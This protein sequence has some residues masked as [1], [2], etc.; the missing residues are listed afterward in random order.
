MQRFKIRQAGI[1]FTLILTVLSIAG[2]NDHEATGDTT[3]PTVSSVAPLNNSGN[4][5]INTSTIATFS[6]AMDP[7]SIDNATFRVRRPDNTA[8]AG[9]V[10]PSGVNAVFTPSANLA[11]NT[12]YTDSALPARSLTP[13]VSV[14][15]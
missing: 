6:E 3:V 5:A 11:D 8:V 7:A 1:L 12:T 14:A 15:V 2:C 9:T 4:V 10:T 13:V